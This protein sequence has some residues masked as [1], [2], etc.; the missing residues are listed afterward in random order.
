MAN[1]LKGEVSFTAGEDNFTLRFDTNA[2]IS[3]EDRLDAPISK[4]GEVLSTGISVRTLRSML[5][6][7]LLAN[8]KLTEEETGRVMDLIGLERA[9]ELAAEAL[10]KAMPRAEGESSARP[11]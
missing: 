7:G 11:R 1:P 10:T 8:H 2:L 4:I 5:W 3:L 6:A 9:G